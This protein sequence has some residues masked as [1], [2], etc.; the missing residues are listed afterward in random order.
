MVQ[1]SVLVSSDVGIQPAISGTVGSLCFNG[2]KARVFEK[3]TDL[4]LTSSA[5]PGRPSRESVQGLARIFLEMCAVDLTEVY[6]PALFNERAMQLGL[7]TGVAAD[8]E[9][10]WNLEAK[11]RCD[12]CS[13]DLRIARPTVLIACPPCPLFLKLQNRND[14]SSIPLE[15][16][17]SKVITTRSHLRFVVRDC[18]EQ[19]HR[20]DHFIFERPSNASSWNES[21]IR[22]LIARPIVFEN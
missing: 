12:K 9:T 17:E 22:K 20:S 2:S 13:S 18:C 4:V 1:T 21:C 7:S 10:G 14:G 8:L 15:S 11:S 16:G 3:L 19:M 6:L 5:F